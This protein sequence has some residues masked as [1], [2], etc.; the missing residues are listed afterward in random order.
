VQPAVQIVGR[1]P[2]VDALVA[3]GDDARPVQ[4]QNTLTQGAS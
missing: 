2:P 3:A 1:Q 4:S